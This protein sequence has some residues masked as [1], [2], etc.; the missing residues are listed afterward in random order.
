MNLK[1]SYL[2]GLLLCLLWLVPAAGAVPDGIR[3]DD[4]VESHYAVLTQPVQ[5]RTQVRPGETMM[6]GLRTVTYEDQGIKFHIYG[7]E[8]S[9][10]GYIPSNWEMGESEIAIFGEADWPAA[11]LEKSEI[12]DM[13]WLMGQNVAKIEATISPDAAPGKYMLTGKLLFMA[14]TEEMCLAPSLV[15][16]SWPVEVVASDFAGDIMVDPGVFNE[17]YPVSYAQDFSLPPAE[18]EGSGIDETGDGG[19]EAAVAGST[20]SWLLD[21]LRNKE[22]K[23]LPFLNIFLLAL[24]GGLILNVMPCV[25]PV[26]SIKVISLVKSAHEDPKQIWGHGFAFAGGIMAAFGV[27]ALIITILQGIGKGLGWGFQFQN[28]WFVLA[29]VTIIFVFGLSLAGVFTIKPP[30]SITHAGEQLAESETIG[31]SFFKGA[32]ATVLGTPCVGPFLG[33][34]LGVAFTTDA[35]WKVFMIFFAIGIGMAIP[36]ILM[37]PFL[38]RMGR[39]ERGQLS[40]KLLESKDKLVMFERVMAFLMFFTA[41]YLLSILAGIAGASAVIWTLVYLTGLGLAAW[42]WGEMVQRGKRAMA[43]GGI[44]VLL[45]VVLSGWFGLNPVIA[46]AAAATAGPGAADEESQEIDWEPFTIAALEQHLKDKE[47][48]F[49]DF[50]AD[51][52]P[53][54]KTN[55]AVA[56]NVP[57]TQAF[58]AKKGIVMMQ[59]DWT[60]E[61][62]EIKDMVRALGFSSIPLVGIFPGNDPGNPI[63]KDALYTATQIQELMQEALDR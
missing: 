53:N 18:D 39:R 44:V 50:T 45:I 7:V 29:M 62:D 2:S 22:K 46:A 38:T 8:P 57:S 16:L 60:V 54:C 12:G 58:V 61:N 55:E 19:G 11:H 35:S 24:A 59:A 40:R 17:S 47:T 42:L 25:L 21:M 56:L 9:T 13:Y 49:V 37:L 14:C 32:L 33:P 41:V 5:D 15:E 30:E 23:Q 10:A 36:Y 52:C 48:V 6:L 20:E 27:L 1:L 34:A 63:V 51:W 28:P 3:A 4:F 43:I 26:V 31:G